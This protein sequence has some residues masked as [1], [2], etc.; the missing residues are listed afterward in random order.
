[1]SLECNISVY[2]DIQKNKIRKTWKF[3]TALAV[4]VVLYESESWGKLCYIKIAE[5]Y[6]GCMGLEKRKMKTYKNQQI[7]Y[8]FGKQ[9]MHG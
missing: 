3:G 6:Q 4:T 1:L 8:L 5:I 9:K 7:P 2:I